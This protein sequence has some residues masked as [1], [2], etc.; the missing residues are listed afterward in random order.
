LPD[1]AERADAGSPDA[2]NPD[3]PWLSDAE[4]RALSKR[5]PDSAIVFALA[6]TGLVASFMM[7]LMTPLLPELPH[8]GSIGLQVVGR[9]GVDPELEAAVCQVGRGFLAELTFPCRLSA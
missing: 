7:T 8:L 2:N 4:R 5:T 3:A 9:R 6:F 1:D